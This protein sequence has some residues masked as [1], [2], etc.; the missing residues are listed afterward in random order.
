M[1][2]FK[3]RIF[4]SLNFGIFNAGVF[5]YLLHLGFNIFIKVDMRF[6]SHLK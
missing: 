4:K 5:S 1:M 3:L 6:I 2:Y